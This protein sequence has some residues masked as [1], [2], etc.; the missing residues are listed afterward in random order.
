[1]STGVKSRAPTLTHV[2]PSRDGHGVC[3]V[4]SFNDEVFV[5]RYGSQQIEVYDAVTFALRRHIAVPGLGNWPTG[6]TACARNKCIYLSDHDNETVHRIKLSRRIGR[7]AAKKWSVAGGPVGLSVNS[8][9]NLVVVCCET[10]MLQEYTTRG[11]LVREIS[12]QEGVTCPWHAVQLSTG[13]YVVCQLMSPGVLSVFGEDGQVVHSYVQSHKSGGGPSML[14]SSLA[15]TRN[16]RILVADQCN[17]RILSMNT[18]LSSV[19][20]LALPLH[21]RMKVPCGLHLDESRGRLYVGELGEQ[22]R[23]LVFDDVAIL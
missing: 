8:A 19:Q 3:G 6:I 21:V 10:K 13:D 12:L 14:P 23:V 16:E 22:H 1:M 20:P 17:S 9:H 5:G 15:V 4:T 2:I 11:S 7:K 18:S